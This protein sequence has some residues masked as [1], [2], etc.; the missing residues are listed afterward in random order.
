MTS[1]SLK[2]SVRGREIGRGNSEEELESSTEG[3]QDYNEDDGI[4]DDEDRDDEYF[5][6]KRRKRGKYY[7]E[8]EIQKFIDEVKQIKRKELSVFKSGSNKDKPS[9]Q[10]SRKQGSS[11]W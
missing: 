8:Q 5:D 11:S 9:L 7:L 4:C 3:H 10:T 6:G 1:C 2:M